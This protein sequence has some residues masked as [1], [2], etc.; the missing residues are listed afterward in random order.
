MRTH[1]KVNQTPYMFLQSYMNNQ[2]LFIWRSLVVEVVR[3][4]KGFTDNDK[5]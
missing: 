5:S 4:Y 1:L 3:G 2:N